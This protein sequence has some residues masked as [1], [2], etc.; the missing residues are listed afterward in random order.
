MSGSLLIDTRPVIEMFCLEQGRMRLGCG[1]MGELQFQQ[2]GM[3]QEDE[4][5]VFG[6]AIIDAL[7]AV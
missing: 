5:Q 6:E 1:V 7:L 3:A 4:A 2:P